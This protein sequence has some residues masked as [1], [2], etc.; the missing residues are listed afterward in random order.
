MIKDVFGYEVPED[1]FIVR[2]TELQQFL[3]CERYWFLASHNGMN[4]EPLVRNNKLRFGICWHKA[5]ERYYEGNKTFEEAWNGFLEGVE[6]E[7]EELH[8]NIGDGMY[9]PDISK[10]LQEEQDLGYK[11]LAHYVEW[12]RQQAPLN[13]TS[14]E[15]RMLVPFGNNT[16]LAAKLDGVVFDGQE[17]MVLEHKAFSKSTNVGDPGNLPL[18]LQMGIQLYILGKRI[19]SEG[20]AR[21]AIYNLARKQ[22]PSSRVKNPI[23]GR[24][25]VLRTL[26]ELDILEDYIS[27]VIRQMKEVSNKE[28]QPLYNPQMMGFCSWGCPFRNLCENLNKGEDWVFLLESNFKDREKTIIEV[29]EEESSS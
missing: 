15:E 25:Y 10:E 19:G 24:H 20:H 1:A 5:L 3:N 28:R 18:D 23:F 11:M 26:K 2:H 14:V 8:K 16:Y 7:K 17:Y 22:A 12:D 29:L 9:D 4:K 6:E 21:A 27:Q 13:V